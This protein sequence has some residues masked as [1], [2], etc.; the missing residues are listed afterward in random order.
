MDNAVADQCVYA[1]HGMDRS[2]K[3]STVANKGISWVAKPLQF[4]QEKWYTEWRTH[5]VFLF[6]NLRALTG[7]VGG[8]FSSGIEMERNKT[9]ETYMKGF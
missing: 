7:A 1:A 3:M 9:K 6:A 5:R 4:G 2:A 8:E